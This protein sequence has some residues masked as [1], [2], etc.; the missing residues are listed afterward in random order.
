MSRDDGTSTEASQY[1][2]VGLHVSAAG[3]LLPQKKQDADKFSTCF[4]S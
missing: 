1:S 3:D 4:N 2:A